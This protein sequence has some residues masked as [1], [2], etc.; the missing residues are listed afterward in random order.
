MLC[1]SVLSDLYLIVCGLLGML[2]SVIM[3]VFVVSV[4]G[5]LPLAGVDSS[6]DQRGSRVHADPAQGP[7]SVY[8][9]AAI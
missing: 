6:Q 8:Q 1:D 5:F 9:R 3:V 4:W 2:C 7:V